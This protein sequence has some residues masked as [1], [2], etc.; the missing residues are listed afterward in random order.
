MLVLLLTLNCKENT[1]VFKPQ[2]PDLIFE[3]ADANGGAWKII[4][5]NSPEDYLV[6]TGTRPQDTGMKLRKNLLE[7]KILRNYWTPKIL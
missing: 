1:L 3:S 2:L 7:I 5:I 4:I 6:D